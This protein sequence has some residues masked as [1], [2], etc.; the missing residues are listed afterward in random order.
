MAAG[1]GVTDLISLLL[2][3]VLGVIIIWNVASKTLGV[4]AG[5]IAVI[6]FLVALW[7]QFLRK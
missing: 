3:G 2:G 5:I 4:I 1:D 6:L 7:N